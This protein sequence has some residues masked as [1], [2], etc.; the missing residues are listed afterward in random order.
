M[1][2]RWPMCRCSCRASCSVKLDG[3]KVGCWL[4][5]HVWRYLVTMDWISGWRFCL[6]IHSWS[7][8][9][10]SFH[11]RW[12]P[13]PLHWRRWDVVSAGCPQRGQLSQSWYLYLTNVVPAPQNPVVCLHHHRCSP[14]DRLAILLLRS[15]QSIWCA[16]VSRSFFFIQYSLRSSLVIKFLVYWSVWV[17]HSDYMGGRYESYHW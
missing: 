12:T 5:L 10:S 1:N 2:W 11:S 15:F 3:L 7:L 6:S 16:V 13:N 4:C 14:A 9:I 8:S 17:C